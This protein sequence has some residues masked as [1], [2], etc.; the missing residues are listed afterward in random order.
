M[1]GVGPVRIRARST[2]ISIMPVRTNEWP[3]PRYTPTLFTSPQEIEERF[4]IV[5]W[6]D[7]YIPKKKGFKSIGKN[8]NRSASRANRENAGAVNNNDNDSTGDTNANTSANNNNNNGNS[9]DQNGSGYE[10]GRTDRTGQ[11]VGPEC[12]ICNRNISLRTKVRKI[13]CKHLF[14]VSCLDYNLLHNS[15]LCPVCGIDLHKN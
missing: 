12:T 13:P 6:T 14:H 4:D 5:P 2:I 7:L 9:N 3:L 8:V 1:E 15:V 11:V 10:N